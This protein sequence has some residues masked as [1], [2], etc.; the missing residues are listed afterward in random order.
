MKQITDLINVMGHP[1]S[2]EILVNPHLQL[3]KPLTKP[4]R[5]LPYIQ[6]FL[7]N[8]FRGDEYKELVEEINNRN[9]LVVFRVWFYKD[10]KFIKDQFI[11]YN[12]SELINAAITSYYER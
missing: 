2:I 11:H 6:N 12:L 10:K 5:P 3:F 8:R 1:C 4:D 9:E 7:S